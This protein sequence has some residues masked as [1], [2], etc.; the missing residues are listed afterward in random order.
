V[1]KLFAIAALLGVMAVPA[2]ALAQPRWYR[3][4]A[5]EVTIYVERTRVGTANWMSIAR[6]G[7]EWSKSSRIRILFVKR[8]PSRLYCVKVYEGRWTKPAAG[9]AT[10]N[11]DPRNYAWYGSVHLNNR[12][13]TSAAARRKAACHEL[14]HAIGLSHR[15]GGRTCMRDGFGTMYGHPDRADYD[16]LLRIY[17]RA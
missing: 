11:Y 1:R 8:C 4:N 9:W 16:T 13:L 14:G 6:A 3:G 12:Y 7:A 17:A 15:S 5:R 2:Q 10:L